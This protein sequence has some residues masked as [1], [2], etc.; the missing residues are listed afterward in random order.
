M[1]L[2]EV[3]AIVATA[4]SG[5]AVTVQIHNLTDT[6]DVLTTEITIDDGE[7]STATAATPAEINTDYD[8][9]DTNDVWRIDVDGAN[10]AEGLIVMMGF[11]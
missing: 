2:V 4:P 11:E 3:G 5:G 6:Q 1:N 10:S 7:T 9:V 8:D